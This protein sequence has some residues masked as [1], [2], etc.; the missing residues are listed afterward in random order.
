VV[1][2]VETTGLS[3]STH[4]IVEIAMVTTDPWGRV[5][6]EWSTRLNPGGPVGAT[7]IH[8]IT[9]AD[10]RRAPTFAQ[11]LEH[12]NAQLAGAAV[13]AHHA[14]FD[15]AFLRAEYA[16]A[17]WQLPFVPVLC[18]LEASDHHLP[19]LARRRLADCCSA[20]GHSVIHAHSALGDAR[21]TAMLLAAFMHPHIGLPPRPDDL[22]LPSRAFTL[23]WPTGPSLSPVVVQA[24]PPGRRLSDQARRNMA[25]QNARPSETL[26]HLVKSFSLVDAMDEGA[27]PGALAYLEKLADVLED[28][29]LTESEAADLSEVAAGNGLADSEVWA[30]NRAFVLALA[31]AAMDDG[32][33]TRAEKAELLSIAELLGVGPKPVAGMLDR[34]ESARNARLAVGLSTLPD[35]WPH[36]DPLRVGDK[37]VFTGCDQAL[38][39]HLEAES[40][41]L[42]IRVLN[43]VSAKTAMLVADGSMQGGKSAK[44]SELGTRVIHP[45]MYGILLQHLQPALTKG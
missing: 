24:A 44:A 35:D 25:A 23:T 42:G 26:C 13:V 18:T 34:A 31:H 32:K 39:A 15:L 10:V 12:V 33:V 22:E 16:R 38:R 3:A 9:D 36:G 37:V 41:R 30:A 43:G 4:R 28:G 27:P 29:V 20:V 21:A 6:G 11:V 40:E 8:G 1:L 17:G 19:H 7:H 2:D 45:A 14:R 5:L